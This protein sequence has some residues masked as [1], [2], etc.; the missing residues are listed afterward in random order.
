MRRFIWLLLALFFSVWIGLQIAKDP[1]LAF[2][3]YRHWSV[4]MPLWFAALSLIAVFFLFRLIWSMLNGIDSIFYRWNDWLR[5]HR[6][7]KA[8]SQTNRGL[9]ELI[10][11]HWRKAEKYLMA[12]INQ[13]DVPL[14]NYLALAKAAQEQFAYDRRDNYLRKAHA[15]AP[16]AEVGI[17]LIQ[18]QLQK[19]QGQ[20]EQALATLNRL[21]TLSPNHGLVLTLLERIYVH[22]GDWKNVLAL[23][24]HLYKSK[25]ITSEQ[26]LL[27]EQKSYAELLKSAENY[28]DKSVS[29]QEVWQGMPRRLQKNPHLLSCYVKQL[30]RDPHQHVEVAG[31]IELL[32]KKAWNAELVRLYGL[33]NTDDPLKQLAHAERWLVRYP[34]QALIFLTLGRLSMRCQLWGK[35]RSYFENSLELEKNA[36]TYLEYGKLLEQLNEA[37]AALKAYRNGLALL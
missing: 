9:I 10:E 20:I 25:S 18:A 36:E 32:M 37:M 21:R 28:S 35:A 34:N 24:P 11:G 14:I 27:L 29:L 15:V 2:F 17:G 31:L 5:W 30:G 22:L 3:S 4:E 23:L 16:H 8:E 12:G 26:L 1:G 19:S 7:N 33:L 13:S 6:K